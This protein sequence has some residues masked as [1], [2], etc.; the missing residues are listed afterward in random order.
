MNRLPLLTA[1]L[2]A[3]MLSFG[4]TAQES[5]P[6]LFDTNDNNTVDIEDFLAIL[7]LFADNDLDDDGVWDSQDLCTDLE[8]CNYEAIPSEPCGYI[9]AL[10]LCGG[11][12]EGDGDGDGICDSEDDCVGVYDECGVCN[13]PGPTE[14]VIDG[15]TIL[16]DSVYA[17]QID[18]WFVFE[19]GADTTFSYACGEFVCEAPLWAQVGSDL[20]G[21][22]E[23]GQ[24]GL[25]V[26]ISGNGDVVAVG[27]PYA[28]D[29][30]E[31]LVR[32]YRRSGDSWEPQGLIEGEDT[33]NQS[34]SALCLSHDGDILAIGARFND[35]NGVSSGHVRV[36]S[37]DS[38]NGEED[39]IQ[40]GDDIDGN[41]DSWSGHAVSLSADGLTVAVGAPRHDEE[42]VDDGQVRVWSFDG[43]AWHLKGS[44][45]LGEAP[46][47]NFGCAV[48]LSNDG[49][50]LAVGALRNDG[51]GDDSGHV[52]IFSWDGQSWIQMGEDIDGEAEVNFSGNAVALSSDGSIVA[53]GAEYNDGSASNSGHVRVFSWNGTHWVQVGED[54]DGEGAA[55][56]SGVSVALS[57]DGSIVAIGAA[58]NDGE[59]IG[60]N[61]GHVRIYS[62]DGGNW[63][64]LGADVDGEAQYDQSG[65]SLSLSADGR[66]VI[67]GAPYNGANG[68]NN[69]GHARVYDL[70][71]E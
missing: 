48:D 16:Y 57:D 42:G 18:T 61:S 50:I 37:F 7:G 56:F 15:I 2:A 14:V 55:D 23:G 1:I 43:N 40:L 28:T 27:A 71:C 63:T 21:D 47:D 54:I 51:N 29:V 58:S 66:S 41:E 64:Q 9:D 3:V 13:G 26:A 10:G 35:Q 20:D 53:I 12:C 39:W 33:G 62:W 44:D 4:A 68:I 52:R 19:V 34:G 60:F 31:G 69:S 6:N 46:D 17:E 36:F 59:G 24:A 32:I 25:A 65:Q 70:E 38:Q 67:I 8:A 22:S 45:L 49:N 30:F 11:G 5:C